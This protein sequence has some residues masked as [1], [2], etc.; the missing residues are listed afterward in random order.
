MKIDI[1][2]NIDN[3]THLYK[4]PD[5]LYR[6]I[7]EYVFFPK[8]D[9]LQISHLSKCSICKGS[10]KLKH[11]DCDYCN[12][13]ANKQYIWCDDKLICKYCQIFDHE[14][15]NYNLMLLLNPY[16]IKCYSN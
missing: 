10:L 14:L 4:L 11:V 15:Y 13:S 9:I 16:S 7:Y 3:M 5:E 2:I 1:I 12:N 6:H 8:H